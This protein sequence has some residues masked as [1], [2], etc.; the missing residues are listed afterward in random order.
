M[1]FKKARLSATHTFVNATMGTAVLFTLA[2]CS[3][4]KAETPETAPPPPAITASVDLPAVWATRPLRGEV[5]DMA[6]SSG[7]GELLAIAY[8]NGPF[9]L[10]NLEAESVGEPS[11]FKIQSLGEGHSASIDGAS[12]TI[13]PAATARGGL[14]AY[15]YGDGLVGPAE[16]DLPIEEERLVH[17]LC[18]GEGGNGLFRLA[19]WTRTNQ[20]ELKTGLITESDGELNWAPGTPI[21]SDNPITAC[22]YENDLP[23][24]LQ[25]ST[26]AAPLKRGAYETLVTLSQAGSLALSAD[27]LEAGR[28]I[29]L[30]NGITVIAPA[31][32]DA[33]AAIGH[34]LSGGYPGGLI[35]VAG[36]T[37]DGD[38]QAVFVDP[39]VLTLATE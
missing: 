25:N 26:D 38:H 39:S 4:Q 17:G 16:I 29:S 12:L 23:R 10:F 13:F 36:E 33:I 6:I 27:D 24:A 11:N 3:G 32:P 20:T 5:A 28:Y 18:S 34:P 30:R 22:V 1:Q 19:Y 35:V 15:I 8:E 2:A 9:E 7:P 21:V 31:E 37:N 14:K